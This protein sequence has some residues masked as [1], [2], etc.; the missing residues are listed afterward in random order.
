MPEQTSR[1]NITGVKRA[2]PIVIVGML[3]VAPLVAACAW[4][5]HND[6]WAPLFDLAMT[7]IRVRDV[8]TTHPPLVGLPGRLGN[9]EI[10]SHPGPL[11][12]YAL[13]PLYRL[14]GG[15]F[16]ALRVSTAALNAVAMLSALLL[17][18]RRA[19]SPGV[20]AAGVVLG[21]LELGFGLLVLTEPWNPYLPIFWFVPFLLGLWCIVSGDVWM[22]P[23]TVAIGSFCAQT[24][25][26]Y[27]A[28]C[29]GLWLL[30]FATVVVSAMKARSRGE[31]IR[32]SVLSCLVA[33]GVAAV[34]WA[35]PLYEELTHRPGNMSLI[36][37]YFASR[38]R[39]SLGLTAAASVV[40]E[41]L[42]VWYLV[43][44]A[45]RAPHVLAEV[46]PARLPSAVRGMVFLAAWLGA[47]AGSVRLRL[48]SLAGL[49]AVV[50]AALAVAWLGTSRIIGAPWHYLV[51]SQWVTAA[52]LAASVIWTAS[53]VALRRQRG[54][55]GPFAPAMGALGITVLTACAIRLSEER[56]QSG[57]STPGPSAELANLTSHAAAA[58]F[59]GVGVATGTRGRYLVTWSDAIRGSAVGMGLL[60]EL[61]RRGLRVGVPAPFGRLATEHRVLAPAD[62]TAR[63]EL[64]TGAW[65]YYVAR[66]PK[67]ALIAYSEPRTPEMRNEYE[68]LRR[69]VVLELARLGQ[70][71]A[72]AKLDWEL[73]A[74]D[75]AGLN[76]YLRMSIA[77]MGELGVATAV[78]VL[79]VN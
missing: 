61:E 10:A 64:A 47:A 53:V 22:L 56:H 78:F 5:R 1:A 6:R 60:N 41:H 25:I 72:I 12:F 27:A 49:H 79:P 45:V 4:L 42:D 19:G 59:Q 20:I 70:R 8:G 32:Q 38:T 48:R 65:I 51:F 9:P 73:D 7:E 74:A 40:V 69:A 63:I 58:I 76:P 36:A 46:A 34:L 3:L 44:E 43:T 16:W 24:H 37:R 55:F 15:S 29:G 13:A 66:Q 11:G 57:S 28:S 77:R 14:L 52:L 75:V 62:A 35:P 18:R 21:V 17:A 54:E 33:L 68:L 26:P 67:A 71:D 23:V 2:W 50:A 31:D 39:S 30:G